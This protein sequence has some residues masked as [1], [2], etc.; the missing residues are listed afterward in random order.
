[1]SFIRC[2]LRALVIPLSDGSAAISGAKG[3]DKR[4]GLDRQLTAVARRDLLFA[5]LLV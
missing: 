3:R 1:L 2:G 5:A 4:P